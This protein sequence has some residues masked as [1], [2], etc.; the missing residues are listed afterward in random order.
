[1][2]IFFSEHSKW[3]RDYINNELLSGIDLTSKN[4]LVIN[5]ATPIEEAKRLV[6]EHKPLI[7]FHLSDESGDRG[8]WLYIFGCAKYVFRQYNHA[9]YVYPPNS[10]QIPLGYATGYNKSTTVKPLVERIYKAAFI[11]E[12]KSDR[13][14]MFGAFE[15]AYMKEELFLRATRNGWELPTLQYSPAA[16]NEV[17]SDSIFVPIG[18]GNQ[19]LDCFRFYE[20]IVSGAIPVIV[21]D[22]NEINTTFQFDGHMPSFLYVSNWTDAANACKHMIKTQF[23]ALMVIQQY[24]CEWWESQVQ[25]IRHLIE[26]A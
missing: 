8:E 23:P 1:M 6:A 16:T 14:E 2:T 18:R 11:G 12:L 3:E 4:V 10:I 13:I 22:I 24:N 25:K 7:V 20:A 26:R 17:Y 15:K 5:H 9:N 21:G 19:S